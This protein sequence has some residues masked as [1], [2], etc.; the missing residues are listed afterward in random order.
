MG[1][2]ETGERDEVPNEAVR[3]DPGAQETMVAP[4]FPPARTEVSLTQTGRA[5]RQFSYDV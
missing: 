2:E 1:K 3:P 4:G 5:G